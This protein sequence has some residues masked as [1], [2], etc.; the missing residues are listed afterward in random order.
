MRDPCLVLHAAGVQACR[1]SIAHAPSPS[2]RAHRARFGSI[3]SRPGVTGHG[4]T[5]SPLSDPR[6]RRVPQIAT[7][8][9]H[10]HSS[11]RP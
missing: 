9:V 6:A 3:P 5:D 2:V 8:D 11:E 1:D 7:V 10:D 4:A